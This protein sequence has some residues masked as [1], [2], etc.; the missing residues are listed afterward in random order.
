MQTKSDIEIQKDLLLNF[1]SSLSNGELIEKISD[2]YSGETKEVADEINKTIDIV[3]NI[4]HETDRLTESAIAGELD[5]RGDAGRF[6][7]E[8]ANIIDG[9]NNTLDASTG[10]LLL[11]AEHIER[12]SRGDIPKR[13]TKEYN[14]DFN[15]IKN[16]LNLCIDSLNNCTSDIHIMIDAAYKGEIDTKVDSSRHNGVY[17]EMI[18]GFNESFEEMARIMHI[19]GAFIE[20]ISHGKDFPKIEK[21]TSGYYLTLRDEINHCIDT[22]N[23]LTSETETLIDASVNG[24]LDIRGD[25][26]G[27]EGSWN[28]I[29]SGMNQ[30]MDAVVEPF[31]LAAEYIERISRGDIPE[32]IT[33]EYKGDY[34]EI[35]N[36]LNLCID[37]LNACIGDIGMMN[38]A[39]FRGELDSRIDISGHKGDFAKI[40]S[41]FNETFEEMARVIKVCIG[42]MDNISHGV[43]PQRITKETWGYYLDV[44][45]N[46]NR[47]VDVLEKLGSET[48][49]I[50]DAA[51]NG[52]LD[53][54]SDTSGL[55]GAWYTT[56]NG[57]NKTM[58]AVV[59]PFVL[60]SEYIERISRGDIPERIRAQ[61][62][63]DYNEINNNLNLCIDALNHCISDIGIMNKAAFKGDLD[64]RIDTSEHMGKYGEMI[65]GFNQTFEEMA[66]IIKVSI[67]FMD[68]ISCG[69]VPQRIT[70]ETWGYY[71][72]VKNN[73]NRS[74]DVLEKLGSETETIIDAAVN[75]KLDVR[76]NT[77][78]LE[79]AWYTTL[80]GINK[81]MDAVTEPFVLAA[82]YI[83][84]ISR[85][86]IPEKIRAQYKGDY[87]EINNNINLCIDA[88][89]GCIKDVMMMNE[90]AIKGD[91]DRRV[92]VAG[93]KGDFAKIGQG[94][95][96]T[97]GE[98]ARIL[99]I[100]GVF[101][102]G[103]R[104]GK[105]LTKIT[106][107]TSGYYLIMKNDI[108][109]SIDVLTNLVTEINKLTE[110]AMAGDLD[111]RSNI[112]EF[113]G[114]WAVIVGGIND[115]IEAFAVPANEGIR[116]LD[117]FSDNNYTA[118][119]DSKIK[120]S[121]RFK[122]FRNSI[123]NV[124][125]QFSTVV[126]DTS[127]VVLEI[128]ANSNEVSKGTNE[129][130]R[131]SEGVATT[132]QETARQTKELLE[133]IVEINR[134]IADLS[135]SNEEIASTSQE[136]LGSADNMVKI[137]I[138]AQK[139][140]DESKVKMAR[141]EDIG[142]K[143]VDEI[144]ALTEQ[145]KEVSNVVKLINDITG[146]INLLALN[147]AIEAARAGEHGRGFAVVAGEVK[148]LAAEARAATDNIEKVVSTVQTGAGNTSKAINAANEE[149]LD[150]VTSV[151][152]TLDG[153]YTI[154][155]SAKQVSSDI[156]EVTKAI[157]DQA[158]IANNVVSS[159][160]KGTQM[161][162]NVQEQAEEL[163]ALAEESSASIE[164]I[165]S[166]IH[167][168]TDLTDRLKTDMEIFRV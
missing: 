149:I 83:E 146:Q 122:N 106:A 23:K 140:G 18:E 13:I 2:D 41:G 53:V 4:L 9:I 96:D 93:H 98:M 62:K 130:M 127:K 28:N 54:R 116:V 47:S 164:E 117:E 165:G 123:D 158:N 26:S 97:F 153:L 40:G 167:E 74:V 102:D 45:T 78:G 68:N 113:D 107:E 11:A 80:N 70:K 22:L 81:T 33:A 139:S 30:T 114:A 89:D 144:N 36:N 76:A 142:K 129:I 152:E 115:T 109:E 56:L 75:G 135:A 60:A 118:R 160:D 67:G 69:V 66:R 12:I 7:G 95:N 32:K 37:A 10:P 15:E 145:I 25:T 166:A 132:S 99:K 143:N 120:V 43:V 27:L 84:R 105:Q 110:A 48:E 148:N 85:G 137:G 108:N 94:L 35:N 136:I 154:I 31:V 49:T 90:A 21:D 91:L 52:R 24:K 63:G 92:N 133:N 72:D 155:N 29:L 20:S 162:K 46:V 141:V 65:D 125:T 44:K 168:V 8:W 17:A 42:F 5:V 50:I 124:G 100:T 119:F 82:E 61:Y 19:T 150:S 88:L 138:D 64:R 112:S 16:N 55:E 147:A 73:V 126:T 71:L 163:A 34:N 14:G 103:V 128:N 121:G 156:G 104:Y 101:I 134:Q 131:A 77:S 58:D 151:N 86:D 157:E 51:V 79:G 3:H 57:I 39:A 111:T 6:P 161:T 59:E 38:K 1:V 87:N 159:A